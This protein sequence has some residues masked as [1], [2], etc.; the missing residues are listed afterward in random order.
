[1]IEK[2]GL[3]ESVNEAVIAERERCKR[4][5]YDATDWAHE[6]RDIVLKEAIAE[7]IEKGYAAPV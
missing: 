6:E 5:V 7:W 4:A 1:M 2:N 3:V